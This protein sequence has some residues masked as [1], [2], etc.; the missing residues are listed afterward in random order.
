MD[1]L[2]RYLQAVKVF[3][4]H[5]QQDD[6]LRELSEN[7][8]AQMEDRA[9]T[10]GRPLTDAGSFVVAAR[11]AASDSAERVGE[12]VDIINIS[13]QIGFLFVVVLTAF[14][15]VRELQRIRSRS[16]SPSTAAP[17]RA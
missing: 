11:A 1:L 2:N 5:R 8:M 13:F 4:P 17:A 12:L 16:A 7:L 9:E 14:E 3:L 15:G 6:I 10:L